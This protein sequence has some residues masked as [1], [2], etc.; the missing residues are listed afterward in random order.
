[1]LVEQDLP[2]SD[3]S[4][5]EDPTAGEPRV[6][7]VYRSRGVPWLLLPPMLILS[8]VAAIIT[9]RRTEPPEPR[10]A[11]TVTSVVLPEAKPEA[12]T[13][14]IT[15]GGTGS[16]V[17]EARPVDVEPGPLQNQPPALI[18]PVA[19]TIPLPNP[20]EAATLPAPFDPAPPVVAKTEQPAPTVPPTPP[21]RVGFDPGALQVQHAPELLPPGDLQPSAK[22]PV[23]RTPTVVG[24]ENPAQPPVVSTPKAEG[25]GAEK[26]KTADILAEINR[27]AKNEGAKR[28][29]LAAVKPE[30]LRGDPRERQAQ[31]EEIAATARRQ[32]AEKREPFHAE[33]KQILKDQGRNG[34]REIQNLCNRYG[35]D[36][37]PEIYIPLS[38]DMN[39][40]AAR[41]TI[42]AR[43]DRMRRWGVPETLILDELC[44]NEENRLNSP[45]G[46]RTRDEAWVFAARRLVTMPP[47]PAPPR[48]GAEPAAQPPPSAPA[49][50]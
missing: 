4:P 35:I 20:G 22:P 43:V 14:A 5:S 45:G 37:P 41:L 11:P 25:T 28:R 38:R 40:A 15:G 21:V 50:R 42:P 33:L 39:G 17:A 36:Y 47:P 7:I 32:E 12:V 18:P 29:E 30:L 23:P 8:A 10:P 48:P 1:M 24:G 16:K 13:S 26:L 34:G 44:Q 19:T 27:E 31:K 46:P 3:G 2:L 49:G 9:Y 6:F